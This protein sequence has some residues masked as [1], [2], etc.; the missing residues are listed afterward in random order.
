MRGTRHRCVVLVSICTWVLGGCGVD[1]PETITGPA[2]KESGWVVSSEQL[3]HPDGL[4][5][6]GAAYF[7][8]PSTFQRVEPSKMLPDSLYILG[9]AGPGG[10]VFWEEAFDPGVKQVR[11]I[12][13]TPAAVELPA[14]KPASAVLRGDF[15]GSGRVD[16]TD[17]IFLFA[18]LAAQVEF[19]NTQMEAG[20]I[21]DDGDTDWQDLALLGAYAYADPRPRTNPHG[22][23]DPLAEPLS[24]RIVPDPST[25]DFAEEGRFYRFEVE[26]S[27]GTGRQTA[28]IYVNDFD[29]DKV[30]EIS[31]YN[32]ATTNC[33]GT[34]FRRYSFK[35]A[36]TK[37]IYLARCGYGESS[38]TVFDGA[39][40]T[41]ERG[42]LLSDK[43]VE[44][45]VSFEEPPQ[46]REFNIG[47]SD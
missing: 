3:L 29:E 35:A 18:W 45:K 31:G 5:G 14:S 20:D 27:G 38:V 16:Q 36:P 2:E 4:K 24:V 46:A 43:L 19:P 44:Y 12:P 42:N 47:I 13:W 7:F 17:V 37:I 39:W 32:R 10:K 40:R 41:D 6:G 25:F 30:L 15:D 22:I 33:R 21:D 11:L 26:M 8:E 28:W 1:P 34:S 9:I 23:G